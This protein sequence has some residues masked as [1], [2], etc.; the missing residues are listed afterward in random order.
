MLKN[1]KNILCGIGDGWFF[2]QTKKKH[3]P[4]KQM[5]LFVLWKQL[6][7]R[8]ANAA[9]ALFTNAIFVAFHKEELFDDALTELVA[10]FKLHANIRHVS[11]AN[12]DVSF[13]VRVVVIVGIDDTDRIG[14]RQPL[15]D[16]I[17]GTGVHFQNLVIIQLG[18]DKGRD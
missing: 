17:A 6:V 3:L 10:L 13:V 7:P 5:L 18:L 15:F 1:G 12:H 14:K 9:R 4:K 16:S 11:Q 8:T 2:S